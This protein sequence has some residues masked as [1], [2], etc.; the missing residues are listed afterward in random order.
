MLRIWSRPPALKA[1]LRVGLANR[2]SLATRGCTTVWALTRGLTAGLAGVA[3]AVTWRPAEA[4]ATGFGS[5]LGSPSSLTTAF[6][7]TFT[8]LG[9]GYSAESLAKW[10]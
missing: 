5:F 2:R 3:G 6:L 7:E 8:G 10:P 4:G 1:L 9:T